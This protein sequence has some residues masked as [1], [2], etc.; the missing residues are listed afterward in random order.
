MFKLETTY[1]PQGDQP[2]AIDQLVKGIRDGLKS[3]VLLGVTGSGKTFSL[4]NVIAQS[5]KPALVLAPNKTLAAQ[6]FAEFSQLF[7]HNAVE[8]FVSYYDYYQPEAYLPQTD[9]FIEKDASRNDLID[10]LRLSATRSLLTRPDVIVV[11]SVSCIYGIGKP[12]TYRSLKQIISVGDTLERSGFLR[13]LVEMQYKRNDYEF[14]RGM[15]RVQGDVVDVFPAYEDKRAVRFSFWGDDVEKISF[16]DPVSGAET[17]VLQTIYLYP[18]THYA[19]SY[20]TVR[21]AREQI[22][23]DL[24]IRL[25][26]LTANHQLIEA[27]RLQQ[28]VQYDLEM[29]QEM[30]YCSGIENYS[31]YLDGRKPGEPPFCLLDYFPDDWLLIIDES[32]ISVPQI[33]GM[34]KGD[35]SRK[36]TLVNFG[37]RLPAALDNRPLRFEEFSAREHQCIYVS[38]TPGAYELERASA[39]AKD[40]YPVYVEQIIR[41]TGLIDPEVEVR[42]ADTQVKDVMEEIK[43]R[44]EKNERVLIT[45]LTKRM[46]E[47]LSAYLADADIRVKYLHSEID[48]IERIEI[49]HELRA[50]EFDVLVGINLLREGLDLPEVSLVAIFDADRRGFLRS[51]RSLI[52]TMGRAARNVNGKVILYSRKITPAMQAAMGETDRRRKLQNQFNQDHSITP[53][54]IVKSL[55]SI[56]DSIFEADYVD[57]QEDPIELMLRD[58]HG[59]KKRHGRKKKKS[60]SRKSRKPHN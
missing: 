12:E 40:A 42:S 27:Q 49:I 16:I 55:D 33:T 44:A 32:H 1:A 50:G 31:R 57:L 48:T 10:R 8:Y 5:N 46:A 43:L 6:L 56:L 23:A 13:N 54:S 11:A 35:K 39:E 29:M 22:A 4:A 7:P 15:F 25:Q 9:T 17:E 58:S 53:Q 60:Q 24:E 51:E 28:R 14:A 26:E 21:D 19:A 30:G 47:D 45:V 34:F 41:P 38:A 59:S 37:F 36:T 18:A 52:Q 2:Q 3:Q 20:T